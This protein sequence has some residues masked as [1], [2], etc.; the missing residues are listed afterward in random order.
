VVLGQSLRQKTNFGYRPGK[1]VFSCGQG[2][3]RALQL[4][5]LAGVRWFGRCPDPSR[6]S[7]ARLRYL[8]NCRPGAPGGGARLGRWDNHAPDFGKKLPQ[9]PKKSKIFCSCARIHARARQRVHARS[10]P[11][12]RPRDPL[13]ARDRAPCVQA[14]ARSLARAI[15]RASR[16]P[17]PLDVRRGAPAVRDAR[18]RKERHRASRARYVARVA[19]CANARAPAQE[20]IARIG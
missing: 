19:R 7:G 4:V 9:T 16:A 14:C 6:H 17:E 15:E 2:A 18:P 5:R 1:I 10:F 12:R 11:A 8:S 3:L 13:P 20:T